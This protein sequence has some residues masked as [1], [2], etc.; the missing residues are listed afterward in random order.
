[1]WRNLLAERFGIILHH[2][3]SEFQVQELVVAKGGSK[4]KATAEDLTAP[5]P[6]GPPK[7]VNGELSGPGM[8]HVIAAFGPNGPSAHSCQG[9]AAVEIDHDDG[10][11]TPLSRVG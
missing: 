5:L 9:A 11:R 7:L 4:L 6:P 8:I 10:K 2:E 3:S 1:M